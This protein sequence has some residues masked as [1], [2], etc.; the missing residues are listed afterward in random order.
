MPIAAGLDIAAARIG[1]TLADVTVVGLDTPGPASASGV[2]SARGSTNFVHPEWSGFD[3]REGLERR[4][5][6]P[7]TYLNDGNGGALWGH[8]V[9]FGASNTATSLSALI[10]TGLGGGVIVC[11]LYTS[12]SPR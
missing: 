8:F 3:I 10:G 9:L 6:K 5:S 7:V 12:P 2:L 4:L 1:R 11:L